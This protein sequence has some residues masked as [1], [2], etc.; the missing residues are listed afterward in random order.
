[1]TG[2]FLAI[3]NMFPISTSLF[4]GIMFIVLILTNFKMEFYTYHLMT[5]QFCLFCYT[6]T[7]WAINGRYSIDQANSIFQ[8]IICMSIF[9]AYYKNL[10]DI[11]ILLK[12]TMWS[13]YVVMFYTYFFYGL[14]NVVGASEEQRLNSEFN[15]VNSL[16]I[17]GAQVIIINAYFFLFVK[18]DFSI[19]MALPT[20]GIIGATQTRKA[21]VMLIAGI[22][23]LYL[24]K[25]LKNTKGSIIPFIKLFIFFAVGIMV[26]Y[27]LSQTPFFSG[28]TH[29][30][31][32]LIASITGKGEMDSSSALR[33]F[34]RDLGWTQFKET[35]LAGIGIGNAHI[36]VWRASDQNTYLHCNY[37]ELAADGGVLGL[38]SYYIM[39]LYVLYK[40]MKYVKIEHSA[41][42]IVVLV[43]I[44][45]ILDWGAVT[46]YSKLPYFT[47][48]TMYIHLDLMRIKHPKPKKIPI[49]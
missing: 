43:L 25:E 39:Y 36:L 17:L 14:D 19:L 48:M 8:S 40:E 23:L 3:V 13:G 1:M 21:L 12:I 37:A 38:F 9:Y 46:Y 28:L 26:I 16:A 18:K 49:R 24:F 35:P 30:M 7:F 22:A 47:L 45:L 32:G 41:I 31:D 4:F 44:K 42:L 34:Y 6:S 29:R 33:K 10:K 15:N 20:L 2:A 11:N 5:L 27:F